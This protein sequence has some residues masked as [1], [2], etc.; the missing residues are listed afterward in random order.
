MTNYNRA[1]VVNRSDGEERKRGGREPDPRPV[2]RREGDTRLGSA[3]REDRRLPPKLVDL[4]ADLSKFRLYFTSVQRVNAT[5]NALGPAG[6]A[7]FEEK[8]A[9]DF[10]TSTAAD[11]APLEAGIVDEDTYV[12]QGLKWKDAHFAYLRYI[13]DTLG[14]RPDLLLLGNPVTDEFGHQFTG[15]VTRRDIDGDPNPYFDDVNGDGV[16][17]HRVDEREGYIRAAYEEA[18]ETLAL[19]RKLMGRKDTTVFASSDHGMAPQWYA[20]NAGKVL[21]DAGVNSTEQ[22]ANCRFAP[23]LP[24]GTKAKACYAGGTVQIYVNLVGRRP[25]G[26]V[27]V[28]E[29]EAVRTQIINAFQ[30]LTDPANPGKQVVLDIL[31]KEELIDVQGSDSLNPTRSGD[32]VVVLRP[33]YQFDAATPGETI[34][35]SQFFGQH[36]YL[37]ELVNLQRNVNMHGTFVAAGPGVKDRGP[38]SGASARSTWRRRLRSCGHPRPDE[39]QRQRPLQAA[40]ENS[41]DFMEIQCSASTTSTAPGAAA[42]WRAVGIG[43]TNTGGVERSSRL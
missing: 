20:V 12:E 36:G 23:T 2:G 35:F 18:D 31:K 29:Y 39:R 4:T 5:Y 11:F 13:F 25:E 40:L 22:N 8:L 28:A 24:A 26:I 43:L 14:Y 1:L 41:D 15:L 42:G 16:R 37:P 9:R 21:D 17:D 38:T 10:P 19:G 6:S 7:D 33:P 30:S 27:P 32:V 34:A 3:G